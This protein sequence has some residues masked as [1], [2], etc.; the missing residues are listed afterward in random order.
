MGT[1]YADLLARKRGVGADRGFDPIWLPPQLY[2]FQAD[3]AAWA[4]RRGAAGLFAD[5]GMGKSPMSLAWAENVRRHAGK[6]VL[7]VAPLA[8]SFQIVAEAAKFGMDAAISREGAVAGPITVTNYD[9]LH[10]FDP[11]DWAGVVCD[12]SSAIKACDGARRALVTRFARALPYRLL[13]SAMAAPNDYTELGTASEALGELGYIEVLNRFFINDRNTSAVGGAALA[14]RRAKSW[15]DKGRGGVRV[16]EYRFKGHAEQPFWRWVASWARAL[17]RPSDLGYPDDGY[18]LPPLDV[19]E[20]IVAARAPRPG[21]MFDLPAV[22]IRE[23][24]EE[25]RRTLAERCQRAADLIA[26]AGGTREAG[27]GI[28]W[29][30][31]NDESALLAKLIPGAVEVRGSD[32]SDEKE[33]KLLAFSRGEVRTLVTKPSIAGHGLNW[34]HCHRIVYFVSH[35]YEQYYQAVRRCWRYGQAHPVRVDVIATEGGLAALDSMRRKAA[36][37][38]RMFGSLV[39][40]MR[41]A[42]GIAR[43]PVRH[44]TPMEVPNWLLS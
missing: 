13:G 7:V 41:D 27:P 42:A 8:V 26:D 39:A 44:T 30:H 43:P 23:E 5:C 34:Q 25:E 36:Q 10:H 32:P 29:C 11:A 12:E 40:C 37:A 4:M 20:H 24:R 6:P 9:R 19:R 21:M 28:V 18:L 14:A 16:G 35:S 3:L 33:A 31:R 1:A 22:G 38:D 17:R 2:P 15:G